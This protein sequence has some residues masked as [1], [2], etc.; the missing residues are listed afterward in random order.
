M[1]YLYSNQKEQ[2]AIA[3]NTMDELHRHNIDQNKPGK[4]EH[5]LKKKKRAYI[6]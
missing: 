2:T 3:Y 1:D 4:K 5:M 6:V